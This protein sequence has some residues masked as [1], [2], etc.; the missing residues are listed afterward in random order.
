M[1]STRC[2]G[3]S[4]AKICGRAHQS[5][6]CQRVASQRAN[7]STPGFHLSD[8]HRLCPT[9]SS[10]GILILRRAG[11]RQA[12]GGEGGRTRGAERGANSARHGQGGY[13]ARLREPGVGK[14]RG[15]SASIVE[16]RSTPRET[17]RH[18]GNFA[19]EA[20][21]V[22]S[23]C[24]ELLGKASSLAW[25]QY[26][27][28][29][30]LILT[31]LKALLPR[32][33]VAFFENRQDNAQQRIRRQPVCSGTSDLP[34]GSAW[35]DAFFAEGQMTDSD[36]LRDAAKLEE[37]LHVAERGCEVGVRYWFQSH[38]EFDGRLCALHYAL[39]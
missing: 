33:W 10:G 18:V 24:V 8:V 15:T 19:P 36:L 34:E 29:A 6:S 12:R 16:R 31:C 5:A 27:Q 28:P 13:I 2:R 23:R 4:E 32:A 9:V 14:G 7:C 26:A 22:A 38:M 1:A 17:S 25:M 20:C 39:C 21:G 30:A 3:Q 11:A 37:A 35:P